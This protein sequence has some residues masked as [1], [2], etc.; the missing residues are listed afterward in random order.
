M[1]LLSMKYF[2]CSHSF[3]SPHCVYSIH[4]NYNEANV[5]SITTYSICYSYSS[6]RKQVQIAWNI[7]ETSCNFP[8]S[9]QNRHSSTRNKT[10]SLWNILSYDWNTV[11]STRSTNQTIYYSTYSNYYRQY[12]NWSRPDSIWNRQDSN[13][14]RQ[15]TTWN[16]NYS[17]WY[18]SNS[19]KHKTDNS[20]Y[21]QYIFNIFNFSCSNLNQL[22]R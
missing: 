10:N 19:R 17:M 9:I 1:S 14:N 21:T 6:I 20:S 22:T 12:S 2:I 16:G 18:Y 11:Y 3:L 4:R 8:D 7:P 15:Y 13:W 5:K